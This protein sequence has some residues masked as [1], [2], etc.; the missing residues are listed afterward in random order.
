[1]TTNTFFSEGKSWRNCLSREICLCAC[2]CYL[3]SFKWHVIFCKQG[4][5][6]PL[7]SPGLSLSPSVLL[8]KLACMRMMLGSHCHPKSSPV[9]FQWHSWICAILSCLSV[10]CSSQR[11]HFLVGSTYRSWLRYTQP[12]ALQGLF[13]CRKP[14][15]LKKELNSHHWLYAVHQ[16]RATAFIFIND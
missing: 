1:M 8:N 7:Q 15:E 3:H 4:K 13:L 5:Q 2:I 16:S 9:I 14:A 10:D 12:T 6:A 11:P